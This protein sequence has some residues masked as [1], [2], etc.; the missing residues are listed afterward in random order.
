MLPT[1]ARHAIEHYSDPG[2]LVVDP[3]C[4]TG[5]VLVEAILLD[6]DAIGVERDAR[7]T[8]LA[9][10]N[11]AKARSHG[12]PGR[13]H[14]LTGDGRD[15]PRILTRKEARSLR[16]APS[17]RVAHLPYASADLVLSTVPL[18]GTPALE[19][20]AA[21]AAS[22]VKPGGFVVLTI[23]ASRAGTKLAGEVVEVC[24]CTGLLYWQHVIA[25]L[26][27]IRGD[28]LIPECGARTH[29]RRTRRLTCHEDVLVFRRPPK[30][31]KR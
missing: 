12:A 17:Q 29:A 21:A 4:A 23:D 5:T 7:R 31:T 25:L 9:N 16:E 2:D 26:A 20:Y 10:A 19:P 15:L 14:A 27:E 28:R 18:D 22:V 8:A 30:E 1:L 6:R 3:R 13:A 11:I 24:Q